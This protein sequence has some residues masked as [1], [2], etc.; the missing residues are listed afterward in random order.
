MLPLKRQAPS[1]YDKF[2]AKAA[3]AKS[4]VISIAVSTTRIA[5]DDR[6][7]CPVF[8]SDLVEA[9]VP[10][11]GTDRSSSPYDDMNHKATASV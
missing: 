3:V 8:L 10:V 11:G 6:D 2:I 9:I 1:R 5:R 4:A 7:G